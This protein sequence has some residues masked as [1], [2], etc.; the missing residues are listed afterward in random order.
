MKTSILTQNKVPEQVV[1]LI[2][3]LVDLIPWPQ[4]RQAMADVTLSLLKGKHRAAENALAG[5]VPW[6]N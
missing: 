5:D 3:R 4:R 1:P 6:S 2:S